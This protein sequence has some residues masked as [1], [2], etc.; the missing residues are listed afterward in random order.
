MGGFVLSELLVLP[1]LKHLVS[2]QE[3]FQSNKCVVTVSFTV[4]LITFLDLYRV[5]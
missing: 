5:W 2:V 4:K 3:N 1:K